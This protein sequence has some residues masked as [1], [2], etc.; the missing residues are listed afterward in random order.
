MAPT[1]DLVGEACA[2][3]QAL[4]QI[5]RAHS[6]PVVW[7]GS[8]FEYAPSDKPIAETHPLVPAT[9]YAKAK[10][11]SWQLFQHNKRPGIPTLTLRPFHLYGP[12]E[13]HARFIPSA[14]LAPRGLAEN[15]FGNALNTRDFVYVDDAASGI[16]SAAKLVV[17]GSALP[18]ESLNLA[19]GRGTTLAEAA[20]LAAVTVGKPDFAYNFTGASPLPGYEPQILLGNPGLAAF[21]LGWAAT[22]PPSEGLSLTWTALSHTSHSTQ[23]SCALGLG[24]S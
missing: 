6:V 21:V 19:S 4:A 24:H 18:Q 14:L 16:V 8:C 2:A 17:S 5:T 13:N 12:G 10:V 1:G 7:I 9:E 20:R 22:T 23:T 15:R 11:H 3:A